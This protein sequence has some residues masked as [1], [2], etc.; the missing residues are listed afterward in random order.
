M[1]IVINKNQFNSTYNRI[2]LP[3]TVKQNTGL[4]SPSYNSNQ[5]NQTDNRTQVGTYFRE[6]RRISFIT[7]VPGLNMHTK[8]V[9][10]YNRSSA[11]G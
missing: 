3:A 8:S 9:Y 4:S 10:K 5:K 11:E 7:D 1:N 6:A 2:N